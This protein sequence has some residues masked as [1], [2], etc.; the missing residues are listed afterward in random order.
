MKRLSKQPPISP[1]ALIPQDGQYLEE[2]WK[3]YV[4]SKSARRLLLEVELMEW[5]DLVI[6]AL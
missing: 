4:R 1:L 6:R 5:W 3:G 2:R